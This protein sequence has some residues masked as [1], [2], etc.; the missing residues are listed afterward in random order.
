MWLVIPF[1]FFFGFTI[2]SHVLSI[3]LL[4]IIYFVIKIFYKNSAGLRLNFDGNEKTI[5]AL[6]LP[7]FLL[8]SYLLYTHVLFPGS[9]G[10]LLGGQSTY[11]DL[12]LHLGIITSIAT[13]GKFPPEYS[14]YPGKL[15]SYPFLADSLSSSMYLLGTS[16]RWS[17]LIPSFVMVLLMVLGFFIL[18]FEL[19]KHKYASVF[20]TILFF[21]NGGFGFIYFMDGLGKDTTNFTRIFTEYYHTPTNYNEHFIR[22][23]NTICDMIIPQRTTMAGWMIAIFAFWLLHKAINENNKTYFV[24]SGI[25]AGLLPMVHT[26]SFLAFGI[27]S[28]MW[29]IV[30]LLKNE[31]KNEYITK[32]LKYDCVFLLLVFTI[33]PKF[34]L[35]AAILSLILLA[36]IVILYIW[37]ND[38]QDIKNY[39]FSWFYFLVPVA[40]LAI[41]QLIFWTFPQS[42]GNGFLRLQ[43]GWAANEG[44]IWSWF[45]IKN[46]GIV[47]ILLIPAIL[48]AKRKFINIYFGAT[49]LFVISNLVLFQPNN[50]D[51]NKLL[52][53]WYMFSAILV[54][55]YI[56][57]IFNRMK[58]IQGRWTLIAIVVFLGTFSGIL[59]IGREIKSAGIENYSSAQV[60]AAEFVKANTPKDSIFI[61]ADEHLNPVSSLAGRNIYVGTGLYL[62]FHGLDTSSRAAE[63]KQMYE[64]SNDFKHLADKNKIDYVFVSDYE[65]NKYKIDL[66]YFEANYPLIYHKSNI[67]IFAISDRAKK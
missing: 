57:S 6:A 20:A 65:R 60:S 24:L 43:A 11:G 58:G 23:S 17:I 38:K 62:A 51:N 22:W 36:G 16:L 10:N 49:I 48:A 66:T 1:S 56:F 67:Y 19:I 47:L 61:T 31:Y 29:S 9:N 12:S 13:Q 5:I 41:P 44:D 21:F 52:Y 59:T 37:Q 54:A 25:T 14:I 63:V 34:G 26:H 39:I 30:Y 2:V 50:Y 64:S 7:I 55:A 42:S 40:I 53:I 33:Y 28:A 8:I 46:V 3:I 45:W 18:S 4:L 15:L 27:I 35:I 32:F